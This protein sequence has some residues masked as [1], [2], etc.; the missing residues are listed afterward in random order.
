MLARPVPVVLALLALHGCSVQPGGAGTDCVRSAECELGLVCIDGTCT[1]NLD[2][3]E[4]QGAV[5]V[6]MMDP[7]DDIADAAMASGDAAAPMN[8]AAV[9]ANDAAAPPPADPDAGL[10]VSDSGL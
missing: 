5:P 4:D 10:P 9:A 8:D 2:G 3:L 1:D 7:A 6:L